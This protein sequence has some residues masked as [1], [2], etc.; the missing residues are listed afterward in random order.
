MNAKVALRLTRTASYLNRVRDHIR[1]KDRAEAMA[2]CAELH[3]QALHLYRALENLTQ[4][5]ATSDQKP[6]AGHRQSNN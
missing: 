6:S 2:D 4:P 1:A 5:V 3:Y